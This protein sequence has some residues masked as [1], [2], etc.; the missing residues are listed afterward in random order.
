[1]KEL[2]YDILIALSLFV[3]AGLFITTMLLDSSGKA[4]RIQ[5]L[6]AANNALN[7]DNISMQAALEE[8]SKK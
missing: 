2:M 7:Q 3:L 4:E 5:E 8:C 6:E 1:M